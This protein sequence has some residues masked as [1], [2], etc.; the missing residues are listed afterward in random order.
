MSNITI[1]STSLVSKHSELFVDGVKMSGLVAIEF[2]RMD[3]DSVNR[4]K[5]TVN[6][7]AVEINAELKELT[8]IDCEGIMRTFKLA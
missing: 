7:E 6:V 2:E 5:L 4:A 1:K 3:K 8:T